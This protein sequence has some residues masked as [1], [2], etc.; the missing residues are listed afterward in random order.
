MNRRRINNKYR[1]S[2]PT[3]ISPMNIHSLEKNKKENFSRDKCS[4]DKK[5]FKNSNINNHENDLI[6]K[7]KKTIKNVFN[8]N[9]EIDDII[10]IGLI[11][12]ILIERNHSN[13]DDTKNKELDM[14]MLALFY[15][16]M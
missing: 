15:I 8:V 12:I 6:S 16:L 9:I 11:I 14:I 10:L 13:K 1:F 5:S 7:I 4:K 2:D 3:E